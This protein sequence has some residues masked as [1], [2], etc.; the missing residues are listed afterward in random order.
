MPPSLKK[1]VILTPF[2]EFRPFR[3]LVCFNEVF[4]W[5]ALLAPAETPHDIINRLNAEWTRIEA[6]PETK[7]QLQRVGLEPISG[8][9]EQC[10]QFLKAETV[11]WVKVIKEAKI[12]NLD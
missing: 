1:F 7:E 11:R 5:Y 2:S 8:T 10:S 3:V 12:P 9:P 4:S 6:M